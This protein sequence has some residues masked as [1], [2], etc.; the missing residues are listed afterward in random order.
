MYFYHGRT[1]GS[2][3]M[4]NPVSL[5]L[6]G[7]FGIMQIENRPNTPFDVDYKTGINNIWQN[8]SDPFGAVNEFGWRDFITTEIV[9]FSMNSDRANYWPNYTQHVIGGGMTS[10]MMV[11]WFRQHGFKH[12]KIWAFTTVSIYHLLNEVVENGSY[13][14]VNVDP[15]ADFYIFNPLGMLLFNMDSVCRFFSET[16]NMADWSYMIAYNPWNKQLQNNGQNFVFK[17]RIPGSKRYSLF[18]HF[19]THG[20]VGFSRRQKNGDS[21]SFGVGLIARELKETSS[22][23][24]GRRMGAELVPNVGLFYDRNN[25]LLASL[26]YAGKKDNMLTLNIYPGL[27]YMGKFTPGLFMLLNRD[28]NVILGLSLGLLPLGINVSI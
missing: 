20:E 8:L 15:I 14:G 17:Y 28:R 26:Q 4:I 13:K 18:Y 12:E 2:E 16:L 6:H 11:E 22:E 21:I 3:S 24:N 9:P 19:G 25:S 23:S 27:F 5:I 10:R 1:Y 7:G